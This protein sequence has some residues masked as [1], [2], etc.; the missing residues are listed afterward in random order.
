M[1]GL[2]LTAVLAGAVVLVGAGVSVAVGGAMV[3]VSVGAA[4]VFVACSVGGRTVS[5]GA[6]VGSLVAG[7]AKVSVGGSGVLVAG[8]LISAV[9]VFAA[10]V[11]TASKVFATSW[12][13]TGC[14]LSGM[15]QPTNTNMRHS[16]IRY[17]IRNM[18]N[19]LSIY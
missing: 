14:V 17:F 6:V 5:V 15:E 1:P 8:C 16:G 4:M 18:V 7:G 13:G 3:F 10:S 12:V 9:M 11:R 19:L 2:L